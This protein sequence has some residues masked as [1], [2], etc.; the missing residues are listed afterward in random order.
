MRLATPIFA[1][2]SIFALGASAC[3]GQGG[4]CTAYFSGWCCSNLSCT[5]HANGLTIY[6][7]RHIR[8]PFFRHRTH[9]YYR[10]AI[11]Q[12]WGRLAADS[13]ARVCIAVMARL[14]APMV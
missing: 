10:R 14:V 11:A 5:S 1:S 13:L 7:V 12:V 3:I 8:I 2:I 6:R 9:T 4:D